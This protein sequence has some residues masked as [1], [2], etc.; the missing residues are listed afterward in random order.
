MSSR[1]SD[2][3]SSKHSKNNEKSDKTREY[4]SFS[5]GNEIF[6]TEILK[7]H[8]V[9]SYREMTNVPSLPRFV[10]GVLNLKGF[11][12]PVMDLREKFGYEKREYNKFTVVM[13]VDVSGRMMGVIVDTVVDVFDVFKK[14][15]KPPPRFSARI[16]TEFIKGMVRHDDDKFIILLDMD[17][18]LSEKELDEMESI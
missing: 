9:T 7:I 2:K 13:I 4:I 3:F 14:D 1:L 10:K 16:K 8:E 12:V 18:I 11:V 6:A 15:I 5:V 17:K